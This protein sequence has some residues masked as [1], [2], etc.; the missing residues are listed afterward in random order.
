MSNVD[1]D[2]KI[3]ELLLNIHREEFERDEERYREETDGCPTW[4]RARALALDPSVTTEVERAHLRSCPHCAA[5]MSSLRALIHPSL[6]DIVKHELG[7]LSGDAVLELEYHLKEEGCWQCARLPGTRWVSSLVSAARGGRRSLEELSA[8][9][10]S[11]LRGADFIEA[12]A[13]RYAARDERHA[14]YAAHFEQG[15]LIVSLEERAGDMLL[16][17]VE[18]REPSLEGETISIEL[19]GESESLTKDV[20]LRRNGDHFEGRCHVPGFGELRDGLKRI[21]VLAA[22]LDGMH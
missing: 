20:T 14:P 22:P 6:L 4:A 1:L 11:T 9:A 21:V 10:V 17:H 8:A 18:T 16:I 19:A 5:R 15:A 12:R 7:L 3:D 13:A 2:K